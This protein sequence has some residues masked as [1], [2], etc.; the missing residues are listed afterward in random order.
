MNYRRLG[1]TN[2]IV[3]EIGF[4]AWGI[5]G[6]TPG[7]T[8]YGPTDDIVSLN[9]LKRAFEKGIT[10]Y[11]TS[12][13]YGAGHS[14]SLIG[15]AFKSQRDKVIIAT[16]AGF[17]DYDKP[18]NFS[19]SSIRKSLEESLIRLQTDYV[20]LLQLHNPTGKIIQK[21]EDLLNLG[22]KLKQE[23]KIRA[24]GIS[25]RSPEDGLLSIQHLKPDAIQTNFS[26]LDHRVIDCGL[27]KSAQKANISVIARTPLCFGFL[28]GE[29]DS[30]T[31]FPSS[32][33]RSSWPPQQIER[34]VEAAQQMLNIRTN[35]KLQTPI[36]FA[37]Q[38][39]LSFDSIASTL[40]GMLSEE[41][42]LENVYA[43]E[44]GPLSKSE[45]ETISATYHSLNIFE[46]EEADEIQTKSMSNFE[47]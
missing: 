3:S 1:E 26:L 7:P 8:S 39:C 27:I 15:R 4:G 29:F 25:V 33:H 14:E 35:P 17:A 41:E 45:L 22:E 20:D 28:T 9:S 47:T 10:L 34:W 24:F 44:K 18:P 6:I 43:S 46:K 13:I 11:D 23:G 36:Q 42:V 30:S 38:F 2:I 21:H 16:K 5:G 40:P 19:P 37:L 31:R 12:N 32:D